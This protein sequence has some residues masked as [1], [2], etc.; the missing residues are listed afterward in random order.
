MNKD[1]SINNIPEEYQ[2]IYLGIDYSSVR[3]TLESGE[4]LDFAFL[5]EPEFQLKIS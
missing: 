3:K 2:M 5:A 4:E 1:I